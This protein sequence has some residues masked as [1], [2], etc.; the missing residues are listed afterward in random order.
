MLPNPLL[1]QKK[2]TITRLSDYVTGMQGG[3]YSQ[4]GMAHQLTWSLF[5]LLL[6]I[7]WS[8]FSAAS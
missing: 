1:V 4:R 2:P 5:S 8:Y 6:G 7:D 3:F